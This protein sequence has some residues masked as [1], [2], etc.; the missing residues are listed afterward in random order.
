MF[1]RMLALIFM[2]NLLCFS[3]EVPKKLVYAQSSEATTLDPQDSGDL[4]STRVIFNIF[5]RLIERDE[6]LNIVGGLAEK[7]EQKDEN[8]L[9]FHLKKG[10]KFHKGQKLTSKDVKYTIDRAKKNPKTSDLFRAISKV[11][12]PDLYT[13]VIKTDEPS[14]SLLYHLTHVSASIISEEYTE[15]EKDFHIN[16]NGTGP[17]KFS[18]W[19]VGSKVVITK[20]EN[21]FKGP[22]LIDTIEIRGIPEENSRVIGLETGEIH[23]GTEIEGIGRNVLGAVSQVSLEEVSSLNG[24]YM[25]MNTKKGPL[26]NINIRKAIAMGIDRDAIIEFFLMGSVEKANSFLTPGV[27][28]YSKSAKIYEYNK[29]KAKKLIEESGHE[30]IKLTLT[31]NNNELRRQMC[32]IIQAQLGEIG[33]E[34]KVE[35]L[36]W[37]TFLDYT[38]QGKTDMYMLGWSSYTGDADHSLTQLIHS[39][40]KGSEGNR[41][42][43][44]NSKVDNLLAKGR[45]EIRL[46]ERREIYKEIQNIVNEEVPVLPI[47][48][49]LSNAGVRK[50]VKGFVQ[51]P[52]NIP[53]FYKLSFEGESL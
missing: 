33:I 10:I 1:K 49:A 29:E 42:F 36:E 23:I 41:S 24:L 20:N 11:E 3:K 22:V 28:G 13:V 45:K 51:T 19:K 17:F 31:T 25:G 48:F 35:I 18:E 46:N 38:G 9:I 21:Y 16:P 14:A 7:W 50:E 40:K 5:D 47:Y 15:N 12:T 2:V 34:V 53:N 52:I 8:T 44:E 26:S 39:S 30:K 6:K 32:E 4:Y 37:A 27:F 43:Y